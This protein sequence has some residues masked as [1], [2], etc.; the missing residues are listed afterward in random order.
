MSEPDPVIGSAAKT[1]L[2]PMRI[3]LPA[4]LAFAVS[5]PLAS[6]AHAQT[7]AAAEPA[8]TA[9]QPPAAQTAAAP[10]QPAAA[11]PAQKT[12]ATEPAKPKIWEPAV[13]HAETNDADTDSD[14]VA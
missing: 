14:G 4:L 6:S 8:P 5:A 9:T 10:A 7:V 2:R 13:I 12:A 3:V 11:K 1:D